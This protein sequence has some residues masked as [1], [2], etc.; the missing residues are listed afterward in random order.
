M[1]DLRYMNMACVSLIRNHVFCGDVW[2]HCG[3]TVR[4]NAPATCRVYGFIYTV[5]VKYGILWLEMS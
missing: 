2:W 5:L 3:G 4:L 1:T